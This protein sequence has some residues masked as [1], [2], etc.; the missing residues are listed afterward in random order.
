MPD[1]EANRTR[2][3]GS[4]DEK[5]EKH[6]F[7]CA[8]VQNLSE[9]EGRRVLLASCFPYA[10]RLNTRLPPLHRQA[11]IG[12][13]EPPA[14]EVGERSVQKG[15]APLKPAEL[16]TSLDM[17]ITMVGNHMESKKVDSRMDVA[18]LT[19]SNASY[20]DTQE[21][22]FFRPTAHNNGFPST[23]TTTYTPSLKPLFKPSLPFAQGPEQEQQQ[24]E[25]DENANP[26]SSTELA[27]PGVPPKCTL[28]NCCI[29]AHG[30]PPSFQSP[31]T[32]YV[33]TLQRFCC[34]IRFIDE[35]ICAHPIFFPIPL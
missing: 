17:S 4:V 2:L 12:P 21:Y 1:R 32:W 24:H 14:L 22:G 31:P 29:C 8:R 27:Q 15:F 34:F 19:G 7:F 25:Q 11:S 33:Y 18:A 30:L 16:G 23:A 10:L 28:S 3:G 13:H 20:F 35:A 9:N 6:E 5:K 26:S